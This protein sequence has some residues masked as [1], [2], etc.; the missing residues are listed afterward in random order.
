MAGLSLIENLSLHLI[1]ES[2]VGTPKSSAVHSK[3]QHEKNVYIRTQTY[4]ITNISKKCHLKGGLYIITP[5]SELNHTSQGCNRVLQGF[6]RGV[7][8]VSQGC[9]MSDICL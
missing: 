4:I 1:S 2:S 7:T 5:P 9:F 6:Y 8:G 3:M